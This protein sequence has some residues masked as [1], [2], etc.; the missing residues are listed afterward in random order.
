[1]RE[2][3]D[4]IRPLDVEHQILLAALATVVAPEHARLAR[5]LHAQAQSALR[6]REGSVDSHS[7]YMPGHRWTLR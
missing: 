4:R 3:R 1:L 6:V 5:R 2:C 7:V